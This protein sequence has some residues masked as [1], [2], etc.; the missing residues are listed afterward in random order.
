MGLIVNQAIIIIY[1][2]LL[3]NFHTKTLTIELE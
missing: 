2:C 3:E 1:Y